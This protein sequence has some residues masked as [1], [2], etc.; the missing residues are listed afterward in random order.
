MIVR[1]VAVLPTGDQVSLLEASKLYMPGKQSFD[2]VIQKEYMAF[3]IRVLKG[4]IWIDILS[5]SGHL[6]PVPLSLFEIINGRMSTFWELRQYDD[7]D[8]VIQ[9]S[10]FFQEYYHDD[11]L[12][13]VTAIVKDFLQIKA[14]MEEEFN[15]QN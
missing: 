13:G 4:I 15:F 3:A 5:E 8:I 14:L 6:Y 7:G 12:E 10:S 11:L 2:V 9:P 1:C